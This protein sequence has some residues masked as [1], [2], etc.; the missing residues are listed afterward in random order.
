MQPSHKP[1]A[2]ATTWTSLAIRWCGIAIAVYETLAEQAD[3]PA[4]LGLAGSMMLGSL[5]IDAYRARGKES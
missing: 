4:L 5:G 3:R 1:P 2:S